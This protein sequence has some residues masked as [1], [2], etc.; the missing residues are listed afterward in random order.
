VAS[1]KAARLPV[2]PKAVARPALAK[3]GTDD[4]WTEF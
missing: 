2:K 1:R 3:T 4:E